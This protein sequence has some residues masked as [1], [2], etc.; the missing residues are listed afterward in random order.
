MWTGSGSCWEGKQK[1]S[2][3]NRSTVGHFI[4]YASSSSHRQILSLVD[5]TKKY[6]NNKKDLLQNET[7]WLLLL[8]VLQRDRAQPWVMQQCNFKFFL[9]HKER[10]SCLLTSLHH[11]EVNSKG[12]AKTKQRLCF[13]RLLRASL[14]CAHPFTLDG[15]S[16]TW[17]W[18][19][20]R[21]LVLGSSRQSYYSSVFFHYNWIIGL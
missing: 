19:C 5:I 18:W 13:C 10:K 9:L 20:Y 2:D 6:I 8:Y 7:G 16:G 15:M 21:P 12:K 3:S 4:L 11:V 14:E 17:G 1:C